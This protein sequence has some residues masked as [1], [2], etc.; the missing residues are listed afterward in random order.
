[1]GKTISTFLY[2]FLI[3][4]ITSFSPKHFI[5]ALNKFVHNSVVPTDGAHTKV[6]FLNACIKR[7]E[8][9]IYFS[10]VFGISRMR[11]TRVL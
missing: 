4:F 6:E 3:S 7:F 10:R 11:W 1:M 9:K 2:Y 8:T 5:C